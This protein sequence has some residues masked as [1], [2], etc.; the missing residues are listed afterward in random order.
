MN[1]TS[2]NCLAEDVL[3]RPVVVAELE[4][5]DVQREVLGADLV[6]GADNT[7]FEDRPKA[8]NGVGV[9][10]ADD[11]FAVSMAND[12]VRKISFKAA[13]A[14]PFVGDQQANLFRHRAA[15]ERF[16]NVTADGFDN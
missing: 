13:I 16:E 6:E 8:F 7:A 11:V 5:G 15:H 2:T 9:D 14:D 1:L 12:A 10:R 4:L 3:I